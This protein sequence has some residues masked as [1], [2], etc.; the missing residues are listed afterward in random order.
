MSQKNKL[1][2]KDGCKPS[3]PV[4]CSTPVAFSEMWWKIIEANRIEKAHKFGP[5]A[6]V[7]SVMSARAMVI[8][9]LKWFKLKA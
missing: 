2:E 6:D 8:E 5:N 9:A 7:L 4:T 1:K 3:A